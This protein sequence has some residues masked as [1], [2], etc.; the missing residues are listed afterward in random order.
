MTQPITSTLD[1]EQQ[2]IAGDALRGTV[3]DL[4]DLSLIAKQAHWNV[5]GRNFRSVHLA[6][7]ELVTAAREF[8]DSAAERATAVG[9]SPD[10]RAVTVAE[11]SGA[12]GFPDGWQQDTDV[13]DAVVGN[14]AAVISRLRERIDATEKADPVT[15]DLFIEIAAR[16]EQLHW[17]W[18]AQ[19]ATA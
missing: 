8:T 16:L 12:I 2:R 13:I 6:L 7:D 17:M 11:K 18:Q 19:L 10:G 14:L 4:I 1:P 15:Q 5:I 3:V 9:V